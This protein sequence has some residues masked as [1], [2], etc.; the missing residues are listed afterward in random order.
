MKNLTILLIILFVQINLFAQTIP[1]TFNY[2]A[3]ARADDGSPIINQEVILEIN[4]MQGTD[5]ETTTGCN[6]IWQEIHYP[7][8]NEFGLF[9]I[10][11]GNGQTTYEGSATNFTDVN[12][13][14]VASGNYFMKMRVDFGSSDYGNGLI[15]MGTIKLQS[16]PYSLVAENAEDVVRVNGKLPF[17]IKDLANVNISGITANQVLQWDGSEWINVTLSPSG[18]PLYLYDLVDVIAGTAPTLNHVLIGDGSDWTN[19]ELDFDNL[20]TANIGTPATDEFL[21]FDGADWVNSPFTIT[22]S[23]IDGVEI[24]TPADGEVLTYDDGTST[25]INQQAGGGGGLW[26]DATDYIFAPDERGI[27]ATG[28]YGAGGNMPIAGAGTRMVFFH[29][30]AAFRAG[31]VSGIQWDDGFVG[32]YSVAFG[33]NTTASANYS[34]ATGYNTTANGIG[35]AVFGE[36]N[37]ADGA[38]SLV[39]GTGNS[40]TASSDYAFVAGQNNNVVAASSLT[41]GNGNTTNGENSMVFGE[42]CRTT[43]NGF[44]GI[45]GGLNTTADGNYSVVFGED[46]TACYASLYIGQFATVTGSPISWVATEPLFVAG[47]GTGTGSRSDAMVLYKNGNLDIGGDVDIAGDLNVDGITTEPPAKS[48]KNSK[49]INNTLEK[50]ELINGISYNQKGI[51]TFGFDAQELEKTYPELVSNNSNGGKSISYTRFTPILVEAV[52]EQQI[53]INELKSENEE[54][55]QKYEELNKRLEKLEN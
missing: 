28:T 50:L 15:D 43:N 37:T 36:T 54:L 40:V 10:Q 55:K 26:T 45:A 53:I 48:G 19:Q 51:T 46:N 44:G 1:E 7:T 20:A 39:T 9:S 8:T 33:R 34:F 23:E 12:W 35:A 38:S 52:K 11:I 30:N 49:S 41:V 14:D 2:Q 25:W 21:I 42:G 24:T 22:L 16:V 27:V 4:I 13:Y 18:D 6:I 47:N 29:G 3:V 32:N 31:R 5:C 17:G